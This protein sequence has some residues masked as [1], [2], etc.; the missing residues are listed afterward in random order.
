MLINMAAEGNANVSNLVQTMVQQ[1]NLDVYES[2]TI[3]LVASAKIPERK[4]SFSPSSSYGQLPDYWLYALL[5]LQVSSSG[6]WC[7]SR[8]S[9]DG[10][11]QDSFV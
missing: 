6:Y 3:M 10:G 5:L 1:L 7:K 2:R 9:G 11:I 8:E 4:G